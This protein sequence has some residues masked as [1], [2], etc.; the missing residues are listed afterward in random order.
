MWRLTKNVLGIT[1][2]DHQPPIDESIITELVREEMSKTPER[3]REVGE[4]AK[5]ASQQVELTERDCMSEG[6]I[7]ERRGNTMIASF[8]KLLERRTLRDARNQW[9]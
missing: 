4:V 2:K 7:V 6:K 3:C 1:D 8:A 5:S 9:K